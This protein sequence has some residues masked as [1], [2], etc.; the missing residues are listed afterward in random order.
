MVGGLVFALCPF[1]FSRKSLVF[2]GG[3]LGVSRGL[4]SVV[5]CSL[6][7]FVPSFAFSDPALFAVGR[8]GLYGVVLVVRSFVGAVLVFRFVVDINGVVGLTFP[9]DGP[10][11]ILSVCSVLRVGLQGHPVGGAASG[12]GYALV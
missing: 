1:L 5:G 3:F 4:F 12:D 2:S 11:E 10:L 9:G 7:V 6:F 8:P